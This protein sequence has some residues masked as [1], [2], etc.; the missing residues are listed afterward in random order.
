ML[1][2]VMLLALGSTADSI[3]D[4]LAARGGGASVAVSERTLSGARGLVATVDARSD[5]HRTRE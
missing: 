3:F 4:W 5:G 1:V 2:A